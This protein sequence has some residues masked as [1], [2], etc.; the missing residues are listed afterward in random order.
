MLSERVLISKLP[1]FLS[2]K[3]VIAGFL[4]RIKKF[5]NLTVL[6]VRDCSDWISVNFSLDKLEPNCLARESV[7]LIQGIPKISEN[8]SVLEME[9]EKLKLISKAKTIP[10]DLNEE[11]VSEEKYRMRYRYLDLR[12]KS[13]QKNLSFSSKA[14]LITFEYLSSLGF[15]EVNTPIL[16]FPAKEGANTFSTLINDQVKESFTLAQSPQIYKQL[17]MISGFE[18]YFQFSRNFRAEKL[19]EDRQYEFTQLDIEISFSTSKKLF[20]IIENL[21]ILLIDKLLGV[22]LENQ[23]FQTLSL[24]DSLQKYGTDKPDL[25]NPL[26]IQRWESRDSHSQIYHYIKFQGVKIEPTQLSSLLSPKIKYIF[27]GDDLELGGELDDLIDEFINSLNLKPNS[28]VFYITSSLREDK[29]PLYLLGSLRN[30]LFKFGLTDSDKN[31]PYKFVWIVDWNYFEKNKDGE[32]VTTHHPFTMPIKESENIFDWKST[33]YDL[34]LN[35][36]EIASGSERITD[37]QLQKEIFKLLGHS[38]ESINNDL[39]WF[40]QALE[41]GTPPHLGIAIG[42]ERL[43]KEL[44]NLPSI[45]DAIAFPKNSHGIC[46]MSSLKSS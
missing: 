45:R 35:G 6:V 7:V 41:F 15:T 1:E 23:D 4:E 27:K 8:R 17:L 33:G 12:R 29:K 30:K 31:K 18:S 40:I 10:I 22:K 11:R 2:Q 37:S 21:L 25:R 9:G 38:E 24:S 36:A 32:L 3:V 14:K 5:K 42:W 13:L 34:V 39:G 44:L 28:H 43:I 20:E 16:S 46:S 26:I 19:R